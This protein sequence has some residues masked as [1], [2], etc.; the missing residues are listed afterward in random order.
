M[1]GL[2]RLTPKELPRAILQEPHP[3]VQPPKLPP[4]LLNSPLGAPSPEGPK[5]LVAIYH[6]QLLPQHLGRLTLHTTPPD[7]VDDLLLV[8]DEAVRV[9]VPA[10]EHLESPPGVDHCWPPGVV[11]ARRVHLGHVDARLGEVNEGLAL[12]WREHV[13]QHDGEQAFVL[14]ERAR[15]P[16]DGRYGHGLG[17]RGRAR[18]GEE[19]LRDGDVAR[20][21][22]HLNWF[23]LGYATGFSIVGP[24]VR[25]AIPLPS[26]KVEHREYWNKVDTVLLNVYKFQNRV[27]KIV[28]CIGRR[29]RVRGFGQMILNIYHSIQPCGRQLGGLFL[30]SAGSSAELMPGTLTECP[31]GEAVLPL[32]TGLKNK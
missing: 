19:V 30:G 17:V 8:P 16:V 7:P 26:E 18:K 11:V 29:K 24:R 22:V 27:V 9:A 10:V 23:A 31:S 28:E 5:F 20:C 13:L 25:L 15:G 2:G 12:A 4:L 6:A 14:W 32:P 3:V 1:S 21:I